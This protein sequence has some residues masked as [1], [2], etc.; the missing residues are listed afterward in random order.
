MIE[1]NNKYCVRMEYNRTRYLNRTE[2]TERNQI[3]QRRA[4]YLNRIEH[5]I[6]TFELNRI[7]PNI[8]EQNRIKQNKI[9][10]KRT[11]F[12]LNIIFFNR[13]EQDI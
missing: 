4:R 8:T 12:K 2:K 5:N 9:Q 3:Q 10:Q 1:Q 6:T 13:E 11:T 7:E